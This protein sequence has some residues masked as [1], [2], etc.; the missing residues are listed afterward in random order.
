MK[1]IRIAQVNNADTG[2]KPVNMIVVDDEVFD[3]GIDAE[4]IRNAKNM[5]DQR[6]DIK[7]S[8]VMSMLSHF[9]EC[10][11]E[12][13]GRDITLEEINSSIKKGLIE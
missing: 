12:F 3:W 5:I 8:L 4:S 7:E 9:V 13:I 10:F 11:S 2:N 6:P 1:K